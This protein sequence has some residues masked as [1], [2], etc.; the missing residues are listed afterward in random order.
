MGVGQQMVGAREK[1]VDAQFLDQ[2]TAFCV[3]FGQERRHA[4]D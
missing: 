3:P 4:L 2:P 1:E